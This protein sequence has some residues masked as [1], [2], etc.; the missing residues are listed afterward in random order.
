MMTNCVFATDAQ[1]LEK[2]LAARGRSRDDLLARGM[3]VAV[4]SGINE[5]LLPG[6]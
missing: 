3:L 4:G 5:Q 6:I 1:G 2:K